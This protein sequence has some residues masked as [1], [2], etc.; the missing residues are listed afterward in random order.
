MS[1]VHFTRLLGLPWHYFTK[2]LRSENSEENSEESRLFTGANLV[3]RPALDRLNR[4]GK[5][6]KSI[7]S[8]FW[9]REF[10]FFSNFR[11]F[12]GILKFRE[13]FFVLYMIQISQSHVTCRCRLLVNV[14]SDR[15][16]CRGF[17]TDHVLTDFAHCWF[18]EMSIFKSFA[19]FH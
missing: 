4:F 7:F 16:E 11:N 10:Q 18:E 19:S 8:K 17:E 15:A 2:V 5:I 12:F 6:I 14:V 9:K 1:F 13:F 3:L